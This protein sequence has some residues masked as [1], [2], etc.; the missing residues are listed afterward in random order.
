MTIDPVVARAVRQ[1]MRDVERGAPGTTS[2]KLRAIK[3]LHDEIG[4]GSIASL[5]PIVDAAIEQMRGQDAHDQRRERLARHL[6]AA[7]RLGPDVGRK[8]WDA[9]ELPADQMDDFRRAADR[10]LA[11]MDEEV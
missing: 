5:A 10:A 6:Y 11:A 1:A 7:D 8:E 4:G 2:V 9:G 3:C